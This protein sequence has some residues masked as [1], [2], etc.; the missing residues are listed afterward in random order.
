MFDFKEISGIGRVCPFPCEPDSGLWHKIVRGIYL[1]VLLQSP[2]LPAYDYELRQYW[3]F[4]Y[5]S[6]TSDGEAFKLTVPPDMFDVYHHELIDPIFLAPIL[7]EF[8]QTIGQLPAY[9][10]AKCLVHNDLIRDFPPEFR[11]HMAIVVI[12]YPGPHLP[13]SAAE[14]F[15]Y[16]V[17]WAKQYSV[18]KGYDDG[19]T[20]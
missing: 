19:C 16:F 9:A 10:G 18:M 7:Q 2:L 20:H 5:L 11:D 17:T 8:V 4:C 1:P 12:Y 6:F 3:K 15:H 14:E 13:R